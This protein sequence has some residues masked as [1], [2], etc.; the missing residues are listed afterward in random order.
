MQKEMNGFVQPAYLERVSFDRHFEADGKWKKS[1]AKFE[2][3]RGPAYGIVKTSNKEKEI[4][5]SRYRV[6]LL[7]D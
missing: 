7:A 3:Q 2:F 5:Y 4:F 6:F 1:Y